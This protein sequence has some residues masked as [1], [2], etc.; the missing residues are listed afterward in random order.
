MQQPNSLQE[1]KGIFAYFTRHFRVTFLVIIGLALLGIQNVVTLPRESA[2]E[3]EIPIGVVVT[4]YP[5]AAARDV[6]ELVT[7][8]LEDELADLEG[9]E[10]ITSSSQLGLS[11]ITVEFNAEEDLDGAINR[12]KES[13]DRVTN[14]PLDA[15]DPEVIEISFDTEPII[16]IGLSGIEDER[17]LTL[18]AEEIEDEIA[19]LPG[20]LGV[21]IV[22]ARREQINVKTDPARLN[23]YGLTIGQLIG[24][25]Q[26]NNINAPFGQLESD[27]FAYDLRLLG[28]FEN[29]GDVATLPVRTNSGATVPLSAIADVSL[30][31]NETGN[32]SRISIDNQP[33]TAAVTLQVRKKTGGNVIDIVDTI[34]E[35][36][37]ELEKTTLPEDVTITTFADSAV[38]IRRSLSDVTRS[39]L[40]TLIIVFI[41]LWIFL[42]WRPAVIASLAIPFTFFMSFI[43]FGLTGTTLNGISLFSLILALGLLVDT[44]IVIVEGIQNESED[45]PEKDLTENAISVI[46]QYQKP[47]AAGTL[48]TVAAF[49]PMLLVSG[50]IGEFLKV[51]PIVLSST[52]L[53]SLF[54]ALALLPAVAVQLLKRWKKQ[55]EERPFDQYFNRFRDWYNSILTR[56]LDSKRF[57]KYFIGG[58]IVLMAVGL[59]LPFTGL[60][61]TGLFPAADIDF[62]IVNM[63]LAPGSRQEQTEQVAANVESAI[64]QIP[65]V[66]SYVANIGSSSSLDLGGGASRENLGSFFINLH[67]ERD[68]TSI[69]IS[70]ALREDFRNVT[71]ATITISEISAGPPSAS[72]IELRVTG[73]DL[74]VLTVLS[75]EIMSEL[76]DIQ[77]AV[78]IDRNLR[79]SAGQFNFTLNQEALAQYGLT[80]SDVAGLL[81]V[82]VFGAEATSF[83]DSRDEE[84]EVQVSSTDPSTS[85]V[86]NILNLPLTTQAGQTIYVRQIASVEL[87]TSI[88]SIRHTDGDRAITITAKSSESS[89][90]NAI[91]QELQKRIDG[92]INLPSGYGVEFGGEQQE[93]VETFN[94]LY[95]SMI[96]A[97][98]LILIILVVEFNS[99]RQPLIIFLSIPL[100]LIGVLFGLLILGGQLNFASFIGLVS[101]TGIVVNNA[102]LLVDRANNYLDEGHTIREAIANAAN[103]RLR[104]IILTTLTTAAGI[105]PLI[106]VDEFFRD[107]ALTIITGLLFST[108]LTLML[109]PILYL[110]Q[111][112]KLQRK[113]AKQT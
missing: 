43:A 92:N 113:A 86:S 19:N 64:R 24:S 41:V 32:A 106:F 91:T 112:K 44:A 37:S 10:R 6:E 56:A 72:P 80:N 12:L 74:D 89:N 59:S 87:N 51:I 111:Q 5:S 48:T 88:E 101:L 20:I 49:F 26:R 47:L 52:L 76:E 60:L 81:R 2:P 35:R 28:R 57:Q 3:I 1:A 16:S 17:L 58:L 42:G 15:E 82:T 108:V 68:R 46:K 34:K 27:G 54:V 71:G 109:I 30:A 29:V 9:L 83:L 94:D 103:T 50:I 4:V 105:T 102:I 18:Y 55:T 23:E 85:S 8:P 40:Q 66:K 75:Q 25:I 22:G 84:I 53:S 63:E 69:E 62:V 7:K 77:G 90:P 14:L 21:D 96:V 79:F 31:L 73:S 13:V 65:E 11:S 78:D 36:V 33:S 93:T 95:R 45:H 99:Y 39:G 98:V 70:D 38:E 61:A 104:P 97:V 100:A 67:E 110:R 107:L